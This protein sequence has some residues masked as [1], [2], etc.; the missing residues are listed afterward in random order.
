MEVVSPTRVAAPCKLEDTAMDKKHG[1]RADFDFLTNGKSHR[2]NHQNRG[3]VSIKADT[4]PANK[5]I[6]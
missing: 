1:N 2:S 6:K 4:D 3:H 5:D